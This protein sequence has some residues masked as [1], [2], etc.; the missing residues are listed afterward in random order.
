MH[1]L[2]SI[3]GGYPTARTPGQGGPIFSYVLARDMYQQ[4]FPAASVDLVYSG[5]QPHHLMTPTLSLL[6]PFQVSAAQ[7]N[8][9]FR[10]PNYSGRSASARVKQSQVPML[11]HSLES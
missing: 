1:T 8:N 3:P 10:R 6:V 7:G 2:A 11:C 5:Q 4:C 9:V